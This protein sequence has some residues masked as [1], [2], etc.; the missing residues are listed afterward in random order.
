M[1]DTALLPFK[2][3]RAGPPHR[4]A[5]SDRRHRTDP[6]DDHWTLLTIGALY[7]EPGPNWYT[8]RHPERAKRHAIRT[9][10]PPRLRRHHQPQRSRLIGQP[11]RNIDSSSRA[12]QDGDPVAA[13]VPGSPRHQGHDRRGGRRDAVHGQPVGLQDAESRFV[14]D[15]RAAKTPLDLADP[16][17]TKGHVFADGVANHL[18]ALGRYPAWND[19]ILSLAAQ[20]S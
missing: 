6:I 12:T 14:V 5:E 9:L 15:S 1:N 3:R 19:Q 8:R 17:K 18:P 20:D 13:G 10:D 11:H 7:D 16:F 4:Q 2:Y